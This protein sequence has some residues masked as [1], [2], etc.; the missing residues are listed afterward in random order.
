MSQKEVIIIPVKIG[1]ALLNSELRQLKVA[2]YSRVSTDFEEQLSSFH[3]QKTHYTDLILKNPKWKL[4]GTYADEGISG[5]NADNRPDFQR[6]YRHCKRG[7]IDLI[8]TKSISRFARNTLDTIKYV[9]KLKSMGVGVIFEKEN[10]N[11]LEETSEFLLTLLSSLAQEELFSLSNNIRKGFEMKRL[12]GEFTL[13]YRT[14]YAI[15]KGSDGNPTINRK[16]A[17][18]IRKIYRKYLM[19]Y[20]MQ[21]IADE[22]NDDKVPTSLEHSIWAGATIGSILE[23]EVY[24]GDVLLGK[25]YTESPITKKIKKNNGERPQ[26]YIKNNHEAIIPRDIFER[27]QVERA[28][29]NRISHKA[30]KTKKGKHSSYALTDI[31]VCGECMTPY[32]RKPWSRRDGTRLYVWRCR[33]RLEHGR[34]YCH[35]SPTLDEESLHRTIVNALKTTTNSKSNLVPLLSKHIEKAMWQMNGNDEVDIVEIE[36]QLDTLKS[37]TMELVATSIAQNSILENEEKLSQMNA[38]IT[39]LHRKVVL[40]RQNNNVKDEISEK[41]RE[42]NEFLQLD[43]TPTDEYNDALVRQLISTIKV[44]NENLE[45]RFKNGAIFT[46]PMQLKIRKLRG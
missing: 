4:V 45:I 15:E 25:T 31:L 39:E 7:K 2:S 11:T 20:S 9:R 34:T 5:A 10:I 23:N 14:L 28:R 26:V 44:N 19:G 35:D 46:Q 40:Y 3:A 16:Q 36:R 12:R 43:T 38:Q 1:N 33:S 21:K 13:Q 41:V 22:L 29:R 6:M 37:Q 18:I 42:Y 17:E 32:A 24:C 27:V 30:D 8:I